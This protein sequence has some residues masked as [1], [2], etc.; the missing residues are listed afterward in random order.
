ME[1]ARIMFLNNCKNDVV[2]VGNHKFLPG[3][4]LFTR[5]HKREQGNVTGLVSVYIYIYIYV[6]KKKL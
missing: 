5:A 2:E 3:D 6:I 4:K 1:E